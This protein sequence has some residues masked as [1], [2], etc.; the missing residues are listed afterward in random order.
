[1]THKKYSWTRRRKNIK[2][3]RAKMHSKNSK[4]LQEVVVALDLEDSQI[5]SVEEGS[6]GDFQVDLE[7]EEKAAV[8]HK[9]YMSMVKKLMLKILEGLEALEALE[10]FSAEE[11]KIQRKD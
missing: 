4:I 10:I 2:I 5:F 3:N 1:M 11:V 7:G 6:E 8:V 9:G